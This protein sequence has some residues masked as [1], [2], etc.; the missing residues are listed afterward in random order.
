MPKES[1]S[2]TA[3]V[4]LMMLRYLGVPEAVAFS[5]ALQ[6]EGDP[7][8]SL[9]NPATAAFM[10]RIQLG[11]SCVS[12]VLY[13]S[14][15]QL[16]LE[17]DNPTILDVACG[18][19]PRVLLMASRGYTYI[20]ADLPDVIGDLMARRDEILPDDAECFAG[21][22]TVNAA[23]EE[24]MRRVLG[25]LRE[26]ITVVTQ[27]LLSYLTLEQKR[28]MAKSIRELLERDGGCW[29]IPDVDSGSLMKDTFRAVLGGMA[30]G[31]VNGVMSFHAKSVGR[32]RSK[33]TWCSADEIEQALCELGFSVRRVPLLRDGMDMRCFGY[34]GDGVAD[35][36]RA[37]WQNKSSI[38]A[39]P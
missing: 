33:M 2:K 34:M 21:Y 19:S 17:A 20:G 18:Y 23:D 25:A 30:A 16:I 32:D 36:V 12:E 24:Q 39:T 6:L 38:V 11:I 15:N 10:S 29:V 13:Q 1:I 35:R 27:G 5:E 26:P 3:Q 7:L 28:T 4:N 9:N 14:A 31:I 37:A 8:E 22:R